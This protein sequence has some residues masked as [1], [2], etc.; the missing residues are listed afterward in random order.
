ML[1]PLSSL[2]LTNNPQ[3]RKFGNFLK[4]LRNR[5]IGKT[6]EN[7][8]MLVLRIGYKI[9][10]NPTEIIDKLNTHFISTEEELVRQKG[11]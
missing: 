8:Q 9:I 1:P 10:S 6:P 5:E 7:E 11:N 3:T 4:Y 2:T